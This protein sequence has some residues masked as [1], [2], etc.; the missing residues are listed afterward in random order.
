MSVTAFEPSGNVAI[1][2]AIF[3]AFIAIDVKLFAA[4]GTSEMVDSFSLDLT[5]V[6]VPPCVT[7]FIATKA[8]SFLLGNLTNLLSAIFTASDFLHNLGDRRYITADVI[9][10]T[11]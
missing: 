4:L 3:P 2:A 10:T 7:A 9:P 6:I 8:F 11:E 1:V 5:E